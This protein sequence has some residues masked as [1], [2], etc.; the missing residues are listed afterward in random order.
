MPQIGKIVL[1]AS[2]AF[3]VCLF[4]QEAKASPQGQDMVFQEADKNKSGTLDDNEFRAHLISGFDS[5]DMDDDGVLTSRECEHGCVTKKYIR[6]AQ[7]YEEYLF[8]AINRDGNRV[9]D[10]AEYLSYMD[11]KFRLHDRNQNKLLEQGEFYAF[12]HG[13]DLRNFIAKKTPAP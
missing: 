7:S 8:S 11:G 13:K 2:C 6:E 1:I 5:L 10:E 12:Y 9:V 4:V 3:A